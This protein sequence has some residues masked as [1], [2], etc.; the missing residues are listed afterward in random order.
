M[1]YDKLLKE[2]EARV[3]EV[4]M[5]STIK[6]LYAD[7][8]IWINKSIP[9]STEKAC[10][11]AEENGHYHTSIGN[12]LD[13]SSI[14]NRKQEQ[15]ARTW[16]YRKLIPLSSFVQAHKQGIHNRYELAEYLEVTESFLEDSLKRYQEI[17]G[18]HTQ[19]KCFTI[20]FDPLLIL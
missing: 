9:T 3:F 4:D 8:V 15:R 11:L 20:Y 12:I 17:Y 6:G 14:P 5:P 2:T 19:W 16:A 13:Q 10:I 18:T 1:L 7:N